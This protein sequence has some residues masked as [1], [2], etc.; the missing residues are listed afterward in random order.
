MFSFE[1][2]MTNITR[3]GIEAGWQ[4]LPQKLQPEAG[5]AYVDGGGGL[6]MPVLAYVKR[7]VFGGGLNRTA[8]KLESGQAVNQPSFF[9][10]AAAG[11]TLTNLVKIRANQE[12][13][14]L[15]QYSQTP[16]T[17][18]LGIGVFQR[19]GQMAG[20]EFIANYQLSSNYSPA[21]GSVS[22]YSGFSLSVRLSFIGNGKFGKVKKQ[23]GDMY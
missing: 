17:S 16:C 1:Y 10:V 13:L 7:D 6:N 2:Y 3:V 12:E 14:H 8:E 21:I 19:I 23:I 22:S 15:K 20:A 9:V 5:R 18:K 11:V 4:M